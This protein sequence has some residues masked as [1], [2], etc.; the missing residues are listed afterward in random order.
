MP[1]RFMNTMI[2]RPQ[3]AQTAAYYEARI[4]AWRAGRRR[5]LKPAA[6]GGFTS[7]APAK[8][9]PRDDADTQRCRQP[10]PGPGGYDGRRLTAGCRAEGNHLR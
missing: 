8:T 5:T 10:E 1:P 4:A 6:R 7:V 9:Q 2:V 3:F